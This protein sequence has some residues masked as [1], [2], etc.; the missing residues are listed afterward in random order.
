VAL[1][2]L[3]MIP[4][5]TNFF[6]ARFPSAIIPGISHW[7]LFYFV[8]VLLAVRLIA[9]EPMFLFSVSTVSLL[10][11]P[12]VFVGAL[13]CFLKK[14][15]LGDVTDIWGKSSHYVSLL[16]NMLAV[17]PIA[18]A[19]MSQVP[20]RRYERYLFQKTTGVSPLEKALLMVSRV[21]NHILFTVIP[22]VMQIWREEHRKKEHLSLY[23][24][25]SDA[26][27][28]DAKNVKRRIVRA[29]TQMLDI[30]LAS[31]CFSLE[32]ITLWTLEIANLP[33]KRA[34]KESQDG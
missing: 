18:I 19:F 6:A 23:E 33:S 29:L 10:A 1:L 17:I 16:L 11:V 27:L 31:I 5:F 3:L 22:K 7:Q 2:F 15:A 14:L 25:A 26:L 24:L 32:Y 30:G 12:V 34:L 8:V 20:L 13:V 9:G 28:D 4:S 21:I